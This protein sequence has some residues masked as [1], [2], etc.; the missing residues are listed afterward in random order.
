MDSF[1]KILWGEGKR[2][3]AGV[4]EVGRG[5]L[6][7]PVIAAAVIFAP[8]TAN[9]GLKDSK[10]LTAARR[11]ILFE[12]IQNKAV[13]IGIG[14]IGPE[15]IDRINILRATLKAM[16]T[17]ISLLKPQ[18]D[19]ILID[20]NQPV[21]SRIPQKTIVKGD[22]KSLSIAAASIIAKVTRDRLMT[23]LHDGFPDYN[24]PGHK[25][26]GTEEHRE[27]IR[28]SGMSSIHRK[29]FVLKQRKGE[30]MEIF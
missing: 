26:Y 10:K 23:S 12:E 16:E 15:E 11:E 4:D 21:D 27:A 5:A 22:D 1:E 6:A 30:Q 28:R 2:L 3:I 20:G 29:S 18:P 8:G 9:F 25:G 19:Y 24:F 17:A 13:S 14:V 7:G